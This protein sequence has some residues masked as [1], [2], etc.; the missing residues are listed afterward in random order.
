MQPTTIT[1]VSLGLPDRDFVEQAMQAAAREYACAVVLK[2]VHFDMRLL[3]PR[4]EAVQ[5]R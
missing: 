2:E 5:C 3:R 1:F 4:A